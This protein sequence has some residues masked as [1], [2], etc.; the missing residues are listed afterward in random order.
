M[1]RKEGTHEPQRLASQV[2][3]D[4]IMVEFGQLADFAATE[5]CAELL[6]QH[7]ERAEI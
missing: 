2:R 5:Q 7:L 1:Q 4:E 6:W 3:T